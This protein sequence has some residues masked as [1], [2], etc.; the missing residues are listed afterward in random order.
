MFIIVGLGNPGDTYTHTRHNVG[1]IVL[2]S[3]ISKNDL[4]SL[5]ESHTYA[6]RITEG[7]MWGHES[8]VLFPT[9]FMNN[10]GTSL[11][12]YLR[13]HSGEHQI[14]VVHDEVDLPF[15]EIR[16]SFDRGSGGHNGVRSII[17]AY[18]SSAF[19]RIRVGVGVK[20]IFGTLKR[21][22]GD[23]LA[24]FVL[25]EFRPKELEQLEGISD[26]VAHALECIFAKG[27]EAAMQEINT[28]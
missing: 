4:P 6:A 11:L 1:W 16:V 2:E 9:T 15:G 19:I 28:G 3:I 10:S 17:D 22:K 5:N 25:K 20:N 27:K 18:Q 24:D 14:I 21:P 8:T 7:N 12:K 23:R 13:A 26:R